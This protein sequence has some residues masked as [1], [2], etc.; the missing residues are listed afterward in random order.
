[1][2]DFG[3]GQ[4][5]RFIEELG[6]E[7]Y[8][9][10]GMMR[11]ALETGRPF[12]LIHFASSYKFDIFPLTSDAFQQTQFSRREIGDVVIGNRTLAMPVAT[13]EDTLLMK[14]VWY[15]AG[16]EASERQWNDVR[17]IV[18]VR[19]QRLDR[20]YIR[21]WGAYLKITDLADAALAF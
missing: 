7:F 9:D 11:D 3:H 19:Q 8:A 4:I 10:A 6:G 13:A 16:G 5:A 2:S 18:A 17:G 20:E 15:R 12:N 21:Y 1:V 14:L